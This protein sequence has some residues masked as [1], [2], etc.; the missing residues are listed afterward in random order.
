M[1]VTQGFLDLLC[2]EASQVVGTIMTWHGAE[3]WRNK[4]TFFYL[5]LKFLTI[6]QTPQNIVNRKPI[7]KT[8]RFVACWESTSTRFRSIE[9][10][11]RFYNQFHGDLPSGWKQMS[12]GKKLY[13][14]QKSRCTWE[15]MSCHKT[16][17]EDNS[18]CI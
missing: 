15:C 14:V 13:S 11:G 8:Q 2:T 17:F 6:Q 1:N 16:A 5:A 7:L 10:I 3:N 9:E 12:R 18:A 4:S